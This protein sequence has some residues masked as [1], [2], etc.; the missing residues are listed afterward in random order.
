MHTPSRPAFARNFAVAAAL[1]AFLTPLATAQDTYKPG[2]KS[3]PAAKEK[4]KTLREEGTSL[5]GGAAEKPAP[6]AATA[7]AAHWSIIIDAFREGD[8]DAQ[9]S[10][11]L[12]KVRSQAGL[13]SAYLEKRGPATVIAFGSYTTPDSK[14]ARAD[15]KRIREMEVTVAGARQKPFAGA[16]L[17][18]PESI[19]G[20]NPEY[21]LAN[22]RR[23]NGEWAL[24]TLQIG[25]YS[26]EDPKKVP[27][28]A[29]RAEFRKTAEV[30]AAKLRREGEQAFYYHGPNRSMVTIGLFGVED[31]DPQTQFS[32]PALTMLRQRY[33]YNLHN[34]MGIRMRKTT[35]DPSTGK[36]VVQEKIQ[37][38]GLIN[39]PRDPSEK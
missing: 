22:A 2:Q 16:F 18:P 27:N 11:A 23:L 36:K 28:E 17:A 24:Y 8:Q 4:E 39:L 15:L 25:V 14:E 37:S 30:A 5:F 29:E 9:A 34:G 10:V 3:K 31:F 6:A 26:S 21:D 19:P 7:A 33:P 1:A 13:T 32:S 12:A 35:T 20:A 38:S